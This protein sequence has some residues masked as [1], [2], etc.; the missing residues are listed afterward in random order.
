[1]ILLFKINSLYQLLVGIDVEFGMEDHGSI[2][3][4]TIER[5]LKPLN[6]IT[7]SESDST[8]GKNKKSKK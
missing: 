1:M 6:T 5:G 4:T 7:D 3:T 2:P 8:N